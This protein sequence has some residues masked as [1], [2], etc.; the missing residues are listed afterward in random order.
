MYDDDDNRPDHVTPTPPAPAPNEAE[1][2]RMATVRKIQAQTNEA[3]AARV[4]AFGPPKYQ[5]GERQRQ[6]DRYTAA[7]NIRLG[8]PSVTVQI[9]GGKNK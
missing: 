2:E 3:N 9:N 4:A 7:R 1:Q 8:I 6:T 5:P